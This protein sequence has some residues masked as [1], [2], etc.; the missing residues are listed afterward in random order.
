MTID[1]AL[2]RVKISST[3]STRFANNDWLI[4]CFALSPMRTNAP[5]LAHPADTADSVAAEVASVAAA[6]ALVAQSPMSRC[7]TY[8]LCHH[9]PPPYSLSSSSSAC[10]A[11]SC[12]LP[13]TCLCACRWRCLCRC[14]WWW[15]CLMR[16][17]SEAE[18]EFSLSTGEWRADAAQAQQQ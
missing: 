10:A 8:I 4:D 17:I 5:F 18:A 7:H 16:T 1:Q 9:F 3:P 13:V 6:A 11:S 15:Y 14:W 12:F 2:K